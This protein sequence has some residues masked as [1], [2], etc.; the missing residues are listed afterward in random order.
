MNEFYKE[1]YITLM[2][3]LNGLLTQLDFQNNFEN[4]YSLLELKV[5]LVNTLSS[6]E[7][8]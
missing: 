8:N 6:S 7:L 5:K 2:D 1:E 3:Q 4:Y